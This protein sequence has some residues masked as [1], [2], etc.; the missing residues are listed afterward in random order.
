MLGERLSN[1]EKQIHEIKS[2]SA[3][4]TNENTR[5]NEEINLTS[6]CAALTEKNS[7]IPDLDEA[8]KNREV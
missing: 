4:L 7:R 8:V 3:E 2:S 6:S 1:F 5:L